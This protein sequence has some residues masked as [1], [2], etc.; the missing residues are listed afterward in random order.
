M[1]LYISGR[2]TGQAFVSL[3]LHR[4]P[5]LRGGFY[6]HEWCVQAVPAGAGRE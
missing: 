6:L 4:H 5:D 1:L 2:D 3:Y